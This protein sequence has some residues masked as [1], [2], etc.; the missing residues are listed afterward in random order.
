MY[1]GIDPGLSGGIATVDESRL[2]VSVAKMADTERDIYD[3]LKMLRDNYFC[4]R[5]VIEKVGGFIQGKSGTEE[6]SKN[7]ASGHTMFTFGS[8]YGALRMALIALE[9]PFEAIAPMTWQKG[10]GIPSRKKT[11]SKTEF[12]NRLKAKA[13][14][15]YPKVKVTLKTCDALLLAEYCRRLEKGRV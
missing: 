12:K 10:L 14:E 3:H 5:A 4:C 11:E 1:I 7:M 9:I 6:K 8:N 2:Y 13:Q 15:L